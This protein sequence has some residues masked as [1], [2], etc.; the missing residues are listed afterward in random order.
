MTRQRMRLTRG[1]D[2]LLGWFFRR[3]NRAFHRSSDGL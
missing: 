1:M 3:F 2:R